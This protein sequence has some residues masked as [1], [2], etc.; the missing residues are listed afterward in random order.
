VIT[1][2]PELKQSLG[3]SEGDDVELKANWNT[4]ELVIRR[5]EG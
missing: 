2:P 4:G 5:L 3:W 1:V